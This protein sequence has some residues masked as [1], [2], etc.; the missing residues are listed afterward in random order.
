MKIDKVTAW[1]FFSD[2]NKQLEEAGLH[3]KWD[4]SSSHDGNGFVGRDVDKDWE[5]EDWVGYPVFE[6]EAPSKITICGIDIYP[7]EEFDVRYY[8]TD[9]LFN[10]WSSKFASVR[11]VVST[12]RLGDVRRILEMA[13]IEFEVKPVAP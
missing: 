9:K 12:E 5:A 8:R 13:G 11:F 7:E 2:V 6:G 1:A 4:D 10:A 3:V